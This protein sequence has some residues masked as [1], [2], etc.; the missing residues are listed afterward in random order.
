MWNLSRAELANE[1]IQS[2]LHDT[3]LIRLY[4]ESL[5]RG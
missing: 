2:L 3:A 4:E 5:P 1:D